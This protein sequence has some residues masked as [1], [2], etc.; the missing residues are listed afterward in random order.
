MGARWRLRPET[1]SNQVPAVAGRQPDERLQEHLLALLLVVLQ[2]GL[3]SAL[4]P[5]L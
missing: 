3:Q 4:R 5:D 2:P 1:T